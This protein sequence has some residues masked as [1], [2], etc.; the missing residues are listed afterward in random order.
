MNELKSDYL[1]LSTHETAPDLEHLAPKLLAKCGRQK[2]SRSRRRD[3]CK[4]NRKKE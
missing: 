3:S 2:R 4:S 1:S